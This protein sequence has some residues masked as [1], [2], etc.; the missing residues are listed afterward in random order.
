MSK[1]APAGSSRKNLKVEDFG[2]IV[3]NTNDSWA[4]AQNLSK[5]TVA[6]VD[7]NKPQERMNSG[8]LVSIAGHLFVATVAQAVP[9][10]S[11]SRLSFVIPKTNT[12]D[13]EVLP[14]L[15]C[16]KIESEWP[17]VGFWNL[18]PQ[19]HYLSYAR[20]QSPWS[21]LACVVRVIQNA[22]VSCSAIPPNSYGLS[23]QIHLSFT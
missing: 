20:R 1:K 3:V 11:E 13:A 6:F 5:Y 12:I 2:R 9:S 16:G 22:D 14:I 4:V 17:D 23:G 8:V 21:K 7:L 19:G 18:I 15:R 10:Q